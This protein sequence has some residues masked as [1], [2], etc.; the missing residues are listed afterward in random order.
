[1]NHFTPEQVEGIILAHTIPFIC[2]GDKVTETRSYNPLGVDQDGLV[3]ELIVDINVVKKQ[4]VE[5]IQLT[6]T[7]NVEE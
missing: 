7:L 5:H 2:N 1:M 6:T 3:S 4:T